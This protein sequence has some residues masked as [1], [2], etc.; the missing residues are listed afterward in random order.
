MLKKKKKFKKKGIGN[1]MKYTI[2][3]EDTLYMDH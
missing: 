2:A 1:V 3:N